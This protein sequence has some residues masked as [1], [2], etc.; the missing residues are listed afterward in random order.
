MAGADPPQV[1]VVGAGGYFGRILV[2]ELLEYTEAH[3]VL[4]GRSRE[5]LTALHRHL[6]SLRPGRVDYQVVDLTQSGTVV[7]AVSNV[8]IAI[9]AA[10][11]F[12]GLPAILVEKCIE[13]GVH[14]IDL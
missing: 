8:Q 10:G 5:R 6:N 11:P 1:L 3:V 9:C 7:S 2:E 4:A 13:R 12:Q 14:Y